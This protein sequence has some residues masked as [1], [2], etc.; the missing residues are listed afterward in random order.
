MLDIA[1]NIKELRSNVPDSVKII[2]VSK[3]KPLEDIKTAYMC[4]IR[5]FGENKVQEL[6]DKHDKLQ[7]DIR[8]HLLGHL[9]RNKVKYIVGKV[10]LIHSLDSV[11]LLDEI[12]KQ[13]SKR[14]LTADALIQINIGREEQKYGV[15]EENLPELIKAVEECSKVKIHGIMAIIPKGS[16]KENE[17][18]FRQVFA[19]WD[20]LKNKQFKNISMKVLSMGMTHDYKIAVKCGSNMIRIGEGIFGK[21]DYDI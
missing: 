7:D 16:E 2:A 12:E 10:H 17:I 6:V 13:Y 18:Y 1:D 11:R 20:E 19:I 3:T 15:L 9:Q 5:D 14:N 21:R 8:W 4:G